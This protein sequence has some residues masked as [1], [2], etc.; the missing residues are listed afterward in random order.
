MKTKFEPALHAFRGFAILCVVAIH[1]FGFMIYYAAHEAPIINVNFV[2]HTNEVLFHD[3][4]I[5]FALISGILFSLILAQRGWLAFYQNKLLNVFLP[6][7]F[8]SCLFTWFNW[9]AEGQFIVYNDGFYAFIGEVYTNLLSG[10]AIFVFWYIPVLLILYLSTPIIMKIIQTPSSKWL[11]ASLILLPLFASR[12]WPDITWQNYAYFI[13]VYTVG[14]LVGTHYTYVTQKIFQHI[15]ALG[16]IA[17][18]TT[19]LLGGL[20][21]YEVEKWQFI[22]LRESIFYIQKITIAALAFAYLSITKQ[23][24][25]RH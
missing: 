8:F 25:T 2:K 3:S 21:Y 4:T 20:F 22:S 15:K 11:L 13:G 1:A 14:L 17:I 9:G 19:L 12:S 24:H 18:V 16:I 6:Y 7:L 23:I 5:F 10:N